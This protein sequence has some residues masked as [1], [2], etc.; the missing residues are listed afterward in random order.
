MHENCCN[1]ECVRALLDDTEGSAAFLAFL[2]TEYSEENWAFYNEIEILKKT[3]AVTVAQRANEIAQEYLAPT[4]ASEVNVSDN[5][6]TQLSF[7]L[8]THDQKEIGNGSL[9]ADIVAVLESMQREVLILLAMG[10]FPRFKQGEFYKGWRCKLSKGVSAVVKRQD[11]MRTTQS[12]HKLDKSTPD[13]GLTTSES[14]AGPYDSIFKNVDATE[15]PIMFS[16][17]SWLPW[18]IASAESLPVCVTIATA[19]PSRRGFPLVYVNAAFEKMSGFARGDILG[20]NC[21]FLQS[22]A[23]EPESIARLQEALRTHSPVRV[24]ITNFRRD[25]TPFKNLLAMKPIFDT[26]GVFRYMVGVQFDVTN[27][28]TSP[29]HLS[30]SNKLI[31]ALPDTVDL[32]DDDGALLIN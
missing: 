8:D 7:I 11:T 1:L 3:D 26:S 27:E 28:L 5:L 6:K 4:A 18:F 16:A 20:I 14:A 15:M 23:T 12:L 30:L 17:R 24:V 31:Q 2:K 22:S 10:C 21:K 29:M 9:S 25:G 13:D 19:S 32:L